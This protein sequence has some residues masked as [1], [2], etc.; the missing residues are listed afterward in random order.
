MI[1]PDFDIGLGS[2]KAS[3]PLQQLPVLCVRN[4]N[5]E[6][7]Q[8]SESHTIERYLCFSLGLKGST[9]LDAASLGIYHASWTDMVAMFMWK[10]WRA[11][12]DEAKEAGAAEFWTEFPKFLRKHDNILMQKA[13]KGPFYTHIWALWKG[14]RTSG[15][16]KEYIDTGSWTLA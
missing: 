8:I 7:E 13:R 2:R 1:H 3:T 6:W 11:K 10:V 9:S 4:D 5:G 16:I 15:G 12:D 14:V